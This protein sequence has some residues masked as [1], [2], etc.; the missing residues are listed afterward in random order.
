MVALPQVIFLA[1]YL[2]IMWVFIA[3]MTIGY[4]KM[5]D[6]KKGYLRWILLSN[7]MLA[8]GDCL[9]LAGA[10]VGYNTGNDLAIIEL[11]GFEVQLGIAGLIATS[12]TMS[13]Y[14]LFLIFYNTRKYQDG[15]FTHIDYALIALFVI[16]IALI[17]N[18]ANIWFTSQLLPGEYNYTA[19]IRNAPLLIFG[20]AS[21]ILVWRN[22]RASQEKKI[23]WVAYAL[24]ITWVAYAFTAFLP[25]DVMMKAT[26]YMIH[27]VAYLI[28]VYYIYRSEFQIASEVNG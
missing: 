17:F 15:T 2:V 21:V 13:V 24:M 26:I 18:P 3:L 5:P 8:L 19:W 11:F 12:T 7:V 14:F 1:V 10:F 23:V 20:V 6:E 27:T 22:A 9:H 16:R 25:L 28:A 4:R